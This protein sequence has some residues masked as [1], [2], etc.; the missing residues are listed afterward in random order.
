LNT[1]G[2]ARGEWLLGLDTAALVA[3][4]SDHRPVRVTRAHISVKLMYAAVPLLAGSE[5]RSWLGAATSL[6][7]NGDAHIHKHKC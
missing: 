4:T 3:A 1:D 2:A 5:W 6:A 7:G